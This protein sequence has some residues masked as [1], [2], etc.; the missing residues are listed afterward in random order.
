M[1]T[2][3]PGIPDKILQHFGSQ[4]ALAKACDVSPQAVSK[5]QRSG[6][7]ADR[8]IQIEKL[9]KGAFRALDIAA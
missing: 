8:A 1:T 9:T 7:P 2:K 5:W 3:K 4:E 6:I